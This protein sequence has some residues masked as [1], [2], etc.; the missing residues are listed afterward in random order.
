MY[1]FTGIDQHEYDE[2]VLKATMAF[3]LVVDVFTMKQA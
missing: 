2:K 3:K 1:H